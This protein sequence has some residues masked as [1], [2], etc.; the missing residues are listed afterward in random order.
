MATIKIYM[1]IKY[2]FQTE[3]KFH[4]KKIYI[5]SN[6]KREEFLLRF[7]RLRTRTRLVSMRMQ[8]GSLASLSGL[9]IQQCP[10]LWCRMQTQ[11]RSCIAMAVAWAGSCSSD[12]VPNLGTS[13]CQRCHTKKQ[14]KKKRD[15]STNNT[16]K[17]GV[18]T[19]M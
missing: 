3:R 11:L 5:R 16:N 12:S 18:Q 8:V 19:Q 1:Q 15:R 9:R 6:S 14:R 2:N 7:S 4:E 13:R 10:K 17:L